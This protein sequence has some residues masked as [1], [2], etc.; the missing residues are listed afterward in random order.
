MKEASYDDAAV[1]GEQLNIRKDDVWKII[2]GV[3]YSTL[4]EL[5]LVVHEAL[6]A[7]SPPEGTA[8]EERKEGKDVDL[9]N[10]L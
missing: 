5:G 9:G 1:I 3:R 10:G 2:Q 6:K 4:G 8:S 7:T